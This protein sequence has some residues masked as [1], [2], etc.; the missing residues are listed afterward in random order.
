MIIRNLD[1]NHDWTFGN[2]QANYLRDDAATL[3]NIQT[4]LLSFLNNCFWALDEGIDWWTRLNR[5]QEENLENDIQNIILQTP[6]VA[7]VNAIDVALDANRQLNCSYSITTDYDNTLQD[8]FAL[9]IV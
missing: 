2:S 6:N 4:R 1:S 8:E 9:P 7:S 3:L 5:G